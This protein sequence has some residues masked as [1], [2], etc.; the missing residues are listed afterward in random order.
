MDDDLWLQGE[1]TGLSNGIRSVFFPVKIKPRILILYH[2]INVCKICWNHLM[3]GGIANITIYNVSVVP[4][5]SSLPMLRAAGTSFKE[6]KSISIIWVLVCWGGNKR[7]THQWLQGFSLSPQR[8]ILSV[9][10][11]WIKLRKSPTT[12][13]HPEGQHVAHVL[14]TVF[15]CHTVST[16]AS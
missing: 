14:C 15:P 5:C 7:Q 9:Q 13:H 16:F 12:G 6:R 10:T 1:I 3:E 8:Q 2:W 11:Q 4:L